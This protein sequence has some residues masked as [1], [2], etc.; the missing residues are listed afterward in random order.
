MFIRLIILALFS[1]FIMQIPNKFL[2]LDYFNLVEIEVT[3]NSKMLHTELTNLR[4]KLYNKNNFDID[5]KELEKILKRD[6]RVE[7]VTINEI[8]LGKIKIDVRDKNLF[9]YVNIKKEIFLVDEKGEIFGYI[10]EKKKE[11]VPLIV[12]KLEEE[13]K[14]ITNILNLIQDRTLFKHISQAYKKGE[15]D[16]R[17]ILRD[18]VELKVNNEVGIDKYRILEI[19]YSEMKKSKKIEYIDLRF[20]DYII[21]YIGDEWY[22]RQW[23]N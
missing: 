9:Y 13:V 22:E 17:I 4:K 15:D 2:K 11:S 6:I 3:E 16:Y 8:G 19:L 5:Y 23:N 1:F 18:G 12:A 10:N 20:D 14:E 21:K 7:N